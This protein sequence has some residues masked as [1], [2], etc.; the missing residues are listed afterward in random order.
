MPEDGRMKLKT[1]IGNYPHTAHLKSGAVRSDRFDLDFIE[2]NPVWDGF[3]G[4][5]RDDKYDVSEMAIVTYLLA[6]A[7]GK[8][9][10]LLPAA[11][12]GRFQHPYAIYNAANGP[13]TPSDLNGKRVGIRSFTTTT[14]AWIRGIL[15]NDYGVDLDSIDWVTF[16]DPHVAEYRDETRRAPPGKAIVPMLLDGEIDAALGES[17]TDPRVKPLFGDPQGEALRWY[18]KHKVVPINHLVVMRSSAVAADP[19]TVR[20]VYRLLLEGKTLA[21]PPANPDP[22]PFGIDANRPS[23]TLIADYA[24]QQKLI[25]RRISVDDMFEETHQLLAC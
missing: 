2:I 21:G 7:H 5:I 17:S 19:A 14:G 25:P 20:E 23:L 22:L 9:L 8:Q 3:K 11:M 6:K 24:Y 15:A 10:A 1:L 12:V 16:E 13:L 18:G 4:M